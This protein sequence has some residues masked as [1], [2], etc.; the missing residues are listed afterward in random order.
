[1]VLV[2]SKLG[3]FELKI[4]DNKEPPKVLV[5][6]WLQLFTQNEDKELKE[7]GMKMLLGAFGDLQRV[8]VYIKKHQIKV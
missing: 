8:A 2:L 5:V 6:T 1:M 7:H 4:M 3:M